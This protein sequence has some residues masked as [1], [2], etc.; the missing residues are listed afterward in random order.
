MIT[1]I[2]YL[3]MLEAKVDDLSTKYPE[4]ADAIQKYNS[5]D[6]TPTKRFLPWLVKQHIA[7]KV[8]PDDSRLH[9]TLSNFDKVRHNLEMKDISRYN[10]KGLADEVDKH[11]KKK[12]EIEAKKNAVDVIHTESNGITAQHIKTKEASQKLYG[13]GESRGGK[14][15]CERGTSWCVAAR[16]DGNRFGSYGHMYTIHDPNDDN[17]PYAVH[18]FHVGG[19]ITTRHNDGDK[20]YNDVVEINPK[21]KNAVDAIMKHSAKNID[22]QLSLRGHIRAMARMKAIQHPLATPEHI[23]QALG[24]ENP[25]VRMSAIS[26]KNVTPEH[27][28]KALGDDDPYIRECAIDHENAT[29]EHITQALSLKGEDN[30]YV[31]EIAIEHPKVTPEHVTQALSLEGDENKRVREEAMRIKKERGW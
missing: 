6:P 24:D 7:G 30:K 2:E 11:V 8:T 15:G 10:F 4:H 31:R 23:T 20:P 5:A 16:S 13:G 27:I 19:T 28:T 22:S 18:P 29:P 14:K 3:L 12:A 1:F 17:A 26:H 21:I 25:D 9:S